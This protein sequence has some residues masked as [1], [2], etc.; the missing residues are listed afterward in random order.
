[1]EELEA[2]LFS[3]VGFAQ[4]NYSAEV[5]LWHGNGSRYITAHQSA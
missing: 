3:T 4:L 2:L 1:M 5:L